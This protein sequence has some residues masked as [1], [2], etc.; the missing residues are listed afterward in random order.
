MPL[1][2]ILT[3][4]MIRATKMGRFLEG[5]LCGLLLAYVGWANVS[6]A[7]ETAVNFVRGLF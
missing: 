5:L 1:T 3:Q 4:I 2:K 6:N 7:I